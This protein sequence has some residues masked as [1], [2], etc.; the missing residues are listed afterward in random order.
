MMLLGSAFSSAQTLTPYFWRLEKD[1]IVSF[2]LGTYHS[3]S[4]GVLPGAVTE[5][6]AQTQL[7]VGEHDGGESTNAEFDLALQNRNPLVILPE[8][9]RLRQLIGPRAFTTLRQHAKGYDTFTLDHFTV[10]TATFLTII[11]GHVNKSH[12]NSEALLN[13]VSG[14]TDN[15]DSLF[16]TSVQGKMDSELATQARQIGHRAEFIET[17]LEPIMVY[18]NI[19]PLELTRFLNFPPPPPPSVSQAEKLQRDANHARAYLSRT[20]TSIWENADEDKSSAPRPIL[21]TITRHT[22]WLEK[23][24]EY[25]RRGPTFFAFGVSHWVDGKASLLNKLKEQGFKIEFI[26]PDPCAQALGDGKH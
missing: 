12:D 2:G 5:A 16:L 17:G 23:I 11:N 1:G 6:L 4:S 15:P 21:L 22:R 7:F 13:L 14:T 8:G 20:R 9:Q 19:T 25:H 24:A 26:Y 18:S 10:A 3:L